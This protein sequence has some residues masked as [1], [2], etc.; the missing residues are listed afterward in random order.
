MIMED[1][2]YNIQPLRYRKT[3][4]LCQFDSFVIKL[5][6]S[7]YGKEKPNSIYTSHYEKGKCQTTSNSSIHS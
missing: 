7:P 4:D 2:R 6:R 3:S 5:L 1:G